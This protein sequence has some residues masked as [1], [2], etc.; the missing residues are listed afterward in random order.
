MGV[1]FVVNCV[2]FEGGFCIFG[3]KVSATDGRHK[4][5]VAVFRENPFH[6]QLVSFFVF[7][8]ESLVFVPFQLSVSTVFEL[9]ILFCVLFR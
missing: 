3:Y 7:V 2:S 5:G 6:I 1:I 9:R 8:L 4:E